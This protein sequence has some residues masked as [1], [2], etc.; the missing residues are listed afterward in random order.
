MSA[1]SPPSKAISQPQC[2]P[3]ISSS[4]IAIAGT[5]MTSSQPIDPRSLKIQV[6]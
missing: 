3:W 2:L 6:P 1:S 5:L 4:G